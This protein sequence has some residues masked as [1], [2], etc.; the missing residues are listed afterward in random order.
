[1]MPLKHVVKILTALSVGAILLFGPNR[2][3]VQLQLATANF[4]EQISATLNGTN[5]WPMFGHDA[6]NS[7]QSAY[8]GPQNPTLKWAADIG[9]ASSE[10]LS[11]PI[12]DK[13]GTIYALTANNEVTAVGADG[14]IKW[15]HNIG[16]FAAIFE[17][18]GLAIGADGTV[19]V[20]LEYYPGGEAKPY[21][22]ALNPEGN[23]LWLFE[24]DAMDS[25]E[26]VLPPLLT[27]DGNVVFTAS[28]TLY[29]LDATGTEKWRKALC[30]QLSAPTVGIDGTIYVTGC[31]SVYAIDPQNGSQKWVF[32][33]DAGVIIE[34]YPAV[35][36]D[37]TIYVAG[38]HQVNS[39]WDAD[40]YAFTPDGRR[41]WRFSAQ[42][43]FV[44]DISVGLNGTIYA[45][46]WSLIAVNRDGS[47][48]WE[49]RPDGNFQYKPAVGADSM[50]Y[51]LAIAG[52]CCE[53]QHTIYAINQDG[54]EKWTLPLLVGTGR[55]FSSPSIAGDGT[56]LVGRGKILYAIG[57][58]LG[59][60]DTD[61]DSVPDDQDVCPETPSGEMV[62]IYGCSRE[63]NKWLLA[64][65]FQPVL[66]MYAE[67]YKPEDIRIML[68][69][70]LSVADAEARLMRVLQG[71]R[72]LVEVEN[73]TLFD[74][75]GRTDPDLFLD[76][77]VDHPSRSP[78]TATL[79][80]TTY[81][82]QYRVIETLYPD[83]LYARVF[84]SDSYTAL[85]YW[86]FYYF[87]DWRNNH[88]GDWEQITLIFN[89]ADI[90]E[91]V[92]DNLEPDRVGYSQHGSGT[93]ATWN[94]LNNIGGVISDT[95]PVVHI[96]FGSHANY[97]R[98]GDYA[99]QGGRS[100]IDQARGSFSPLY[101]IQL[102]SANL[103]TASCEDGKWLEY[104][105]RWGELRIEP[106]T[107]GLV[108]PKFQGDKWDDPI[109]WVDS[110][111]A[112][113][114]DCRKTLFKC[115]IP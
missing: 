56:I 27:P 114:R 28:H 71:P 17:T 64:Q 89:S 12:V 110:L 46:S 11:I 63:Q 86:F 77:K 107:T 54:V 76:L 87:N 91:I 38:G 98:S 4:V 53:W 62:D 73:P 61:G 2:G 74:L 104:A 29:V 37:G 52:P 101:T 105:G 16:G 102:L 44:T 43:G 85:Q 24:G 92:H 34:T 36:H 48:K 3:P 55:G 10:I 51:A 14:R 103:T 79:D 93:R 58:G 5:P 35:G 7:S 115:R 57:P 67:D 50:I 23:K 30:G 18:F 41:L 96:A 13:N 15:R 59:I 94:Q 78:A 45:G 9:G 60:P 8:I 108:G 99:L 68:S 65:K 75:C 42:H 88:E 33:A 31:N 21:L 113:W 80:Q 20:A 106:Q 66:K 1:M 69:S 95:H 49:F 83:T 26:D 90:S 25:R 6:R 40:I 100:T 19:Y 112:S 97:F 32:V 47:L 72:D 81:L 82:N 70:S 39:N 111:E 84:T 22:I 109:D